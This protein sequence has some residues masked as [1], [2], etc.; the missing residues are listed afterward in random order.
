[1]YLGILSDAI[2]TNAGIS[3]P[4]SKE[5]TEKVQRLK[6][7]Y[8]NKPILY[9]GARHYHWSLDNEIA[10]AALEGGAVQTSSDIGSSN[11][12]KEGEGTIPHVLVL[13]LAYKYG[14]EIATLKAA[15]LFDKYMSEEIPRVT[16]IDTFNRELSDAL[17]VAKYFEKRK[18]SF[19]LD[20]CGENIGEGG[21]GK[22]KDSMYQIG[23][24][25]TIELVRNLRN[26][27]ISSEFANNTDIILS[28]GFG[29]EEKAKAFMK[30]DEE[31]KKKTGYELF[32]TLGI[33]EVSEAKFCTADIFEIE[34]KPFSKVGREIDS[35]DYSSMER[36]I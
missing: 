33:G 36:I 25:V 21:T 34:D 24:G 26:L 32:S 22:T 31:F 35:I 7:I 29:N 27:L 4:D 10:K 8:G 9:F 19:R 17:S 13:L 5:I 12:N 23:T 15:E 14:K 3:R 20:T 28:S 30:A 6:S 16:L 18:N 1:M 11:I 2:T